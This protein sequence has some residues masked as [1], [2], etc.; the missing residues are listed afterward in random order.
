MFLVLNLK[1]WETRYYL[2]FVPFMGAGIGLAFAY[3]RSQAAR[4]SRRG[5]LAAIL[6]LSLAVATLQTGASFRRGWWDL[7]TDA[8]GAARFLAAWG[9]PPGSVVIARKPHICFYSGLECGAFPNVAQLE[10]L[11]ASIEQS[12]QEWSPDAKVFLFFGFAEKALRPTLARPLHGWAQVPWLHR[13][14]EGGERHMRWILFEVVRESLGSEE[15]PTG[16]VDTP[17][18]QAARRP[19]GAHAE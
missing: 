8:Q 6:G 1:A 16:R 3:L 18:R 11:R 19:E 10:G 2:L 5:A 7:S 4:T 9:A 14:G 13:V 15:T 17:R 12:A